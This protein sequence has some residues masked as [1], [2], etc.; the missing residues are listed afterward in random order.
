MKKYA[1]KS[2]LFKIYFIYDWNALITIEFFPVSDRISLAGK[3][4]LILI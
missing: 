4:F 3:K 1:L 2:P